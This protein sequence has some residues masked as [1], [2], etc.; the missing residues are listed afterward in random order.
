MS[1]RGWRIYVAAEV[2]LVAGY[3]IVPVG[4]WWTAGPQVLVGWTAAG[5]ILAGVRHLPPRDRPPW[6]FLAFGVFCSS[7]APILVEFDIPV[8]VGADVLFLAFYP[9]CAVALALMIRQLRRRPD[10]AALVDALTVTVGI[11]LLAWVYAILPGWN[12]PESSLAERSV[13]VAYP[14]CDLLLLA[15]TILL[16]RSNGRLGGSAPRW[17]AVAIVG[18]LAGDWAWV[19]LGSLHNG[20]AD[21][22]WTTR[23]ING[24]YI[25]SLAAMGLAARH[26]KLRDAGPG[27]AA[28]SRLGPGQLA[29]LAVAVLIAPGLLVAQVADRRV[30]NGLAIAIGSAT[31]FL[32]VV[33]RMGQLLRQADKQSQQVRELARR[34]ELTG[35]PNRRAWTDELPRALEQARRDGSQIS[36]AMIDLDRFKDFNDRYGHP[37]GD[38]LLKEAAAAWHSALRR[39]DILARYGGEEFIV[40]LPG[41][42]IEH[43]AG[44][45]SRVQAVTPGEQTFSAGVATWNG[46][47]T[48]DDL[49]VR[50][51]AAL[52]AAKAQGRD[53]VVSAAS[54]P[55]PGSLPFAGSEAPAAEV[56]RS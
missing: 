54:P 25:L 2:L 53:R 51:D 17:I 35:L 19:V 31:M 49:I 18:Y 10:W 4:R 47:E 39:S 33:L 48:S 16:L 20:W 6:W 14:I 3:E 24:V 29:M 55:C 28:V 22:A 15:M 30:G 45:L 21:L 36:V 12:D 34:D 42:D 38:R 26:P 11:G 40:L 44:V 7:T 23:A 37:A 56:G 46:T 43:A 27:A 50:A 9:A 52:Y 41:A 5:S 32:L 1:G 8:M 13:R